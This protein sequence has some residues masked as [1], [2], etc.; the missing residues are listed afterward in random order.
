MAKYGRFIVAEG[1]DGVG[2]STISKLLAKEL[3]AVWTREPT[4]WL[5]ARISQEDWGSF[6][7][8]EQA[9]LFSADRAMHL[10]DVI[11]PAL[12]K[13]ETVICDRYD[14]STF[15]YQMV[16]AGCGGEKRGEGER[17]VEREYRKLLG[18]LGKDNDTPNA[19][20]V[21]TLTE[22]ELSERIVQRGLA[23]S[24]YEQPERQQRA[25]RS[26]FTEAD[27]MADAG[28]SIYYVDASGSENDVLRR[29]LAVLDTARLR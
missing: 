27:A 3:H 24:Y 12:A 23:L 1:C 22:P 6:S 4:N 9:L 17:L 16:D 29:C 28:R 2:K 8:W 19:I 7:W 20:L 14:L 18:Q 13:G 11:R 15:V 21:F 5:I 26:Y 25:I 10:H